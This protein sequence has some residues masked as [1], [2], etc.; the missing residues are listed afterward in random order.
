MYDAV[1]TVDLESA[2]E[3]PFDKRI[4]EA[5]EL[6]S[7]ILALAREVKYEYDEAIRRL[8]KQHGVKTEFEIWTTFILEHNH[9]SRDFKIAEEL[10]ETVAGLKTQFQNVCYERAGTTPQER[11]WGK[12]RLFV[13]AMYTVTAQE[14]AQANRECESR[15]LAAGRWVPDRERTPEAMP[16]MSFAWLFRRE[17]GHIAMRRSQFDSV[18][19][20][21][22]NNSASF[23]PLVPVDPSISTSPG[24]AVQLPE[25]EPPA[26][27]KGND[28]KDSFEL[29]PL[30]PIDTPVA[31]NSPNGVSDNQSFTSSSGSALLEMHELSSSTPSLEVLEHVL[32]G[33]SAFDLSDQESLHEGAAELIA[34]KN[35]L[36]S[37]RAA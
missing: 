15:H 24:G 11:D 27:V 2:W 37:T 30:D 12:V 36:G 3:L 8:M 22:A 19:L 29:I 5:F 28:R 10:G 14:V 20:P 32:S 21:T 17:L 34:P 35:L 26:E 4:L 16:F 25:H 18:H 1:I 9:E 7:R 23:T 13:A 6:D 33:S 31:Q